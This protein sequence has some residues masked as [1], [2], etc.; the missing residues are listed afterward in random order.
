[1]REYLDARDDKYEL[2]IAD[3]SSAIDI[4]DLGPAI[5]LDRGLSELNLG[6]WSAAEQDFTKGL[7]LCDCCN[8]DYYPRL[9]IFCVA[10]A[11][12]R[13]GPNF[14]FWTNKLVTKAELLAE[15][16]S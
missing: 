2:A 9:Y 5:V 12:G 13:H 15:C 6:D 1:L 16:L 14:S 11:R 10:Q 8:D 3:L 7:G 4:C